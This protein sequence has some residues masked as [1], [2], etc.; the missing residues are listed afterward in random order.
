MSVSTVVF[1]RDKTQSQDDD[2]VRRRI[3]NW[4]FFEFE[5]DTIEGRLFSDRKTTRKTSRQPFLDTIELW[6]AIR[7]AGGFDP[8]YYFYKTNFWQIKGVETYAISI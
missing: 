4:H 2:W 7:D 5:Y 1:R 8:F 3:G 6:T